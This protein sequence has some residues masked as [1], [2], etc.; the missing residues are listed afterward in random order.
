VIQSGRGPSPRAGK[1]TGT[2][3][4][5]PPG[6][7]R[8]RHNTNQRPKPRWSSTPPAVKPLKPAEKSKSG[9]RGEQG[10][11]PPLAPLAVRAARAAR[12]LP[13][14]HSS[15]LPLGSQAP[16]P[17]APLGRSPAPLAPLAPVGARCIR[18]PPPAQ[19]AMRNPRQARAIV[20]HAC[21]S[22]PLPNRRCTQARPS[23]HGF[24]RGAAG[25]ATTR[26]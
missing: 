18:A 14:R 21:Q 9:A 22:Q 20:R 25:R 24:F 7:A 11:V 17:A 8:T 13:R 1:V 15:C 2:A 16:T 10:F 23:A 6:T 19:H 26:R 5:H 4:R 3:P 12:S